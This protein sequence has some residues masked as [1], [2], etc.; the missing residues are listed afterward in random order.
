MIEQKRSPDAFAPHMDYIARYHKSYADL[1]DKILQGNI[2]SDGHDGG[3]ENENDNSEGEDNEAGAR[4]EAEAEAEAEERRGNA[5]NESERDLQNEGS[6]KVNVQ[7]AEEKGLDEVTDQ[8]REMEKEDLKEDARREEGESSSHGLN[9]DNDRT[10]QSTYPAVAESESG[11]HFIIS[12]EE[13][14]LEVD[15]LKQLLA[16][17]VSFEVEA[18]QMLLD[19]MEK[20][21]ERT[22][23]L[24]DRNG[25]RYSSH[26]FPSVLPDNLRIKL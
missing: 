26:S 12:K 15:L 2:A 7:G 22:I 14:Q 4:A 24:A 13:R 20:S 25:E 19:S 8:I 11:S 10:E 6:T 5:S 16:K 23:L 18:R 21:V 9:S 17:T 3:R 1:R